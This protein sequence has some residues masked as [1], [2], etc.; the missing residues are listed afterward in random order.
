M[1]FQKELSQLSTIDFDQAKKTLQGPI[2]EKKIQLLLT[3]VL[4]KLTKV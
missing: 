2:K 3:L 1:Y 4:I